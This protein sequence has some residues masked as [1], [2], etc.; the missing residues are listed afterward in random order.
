MKKTSLRLA[1]LILT[2]ALAEIAN[3]TPLNP[4]FESGDT[5]DW[6]VS[7][8]LGTSWLPPFQQPAGEVVIVSNWNPETSEGTAIRPVAGNSFARVGT[9]AAGFFTGGLIYDIYLT[10]SISL[11]QGDILSGWSLFYNGDNASQDSAWVK[12]TDSADN[13]IANPWLAVSGYSS[14]VTP[15]MTPYLSA[16]AWTSW[17]W[18][19]PATGTYQLKLGV[20]TF[21]DNNFASYGLFDDI[22]LSSASGL[23][24][25]TAMPEPSATTLFGLGFAAFAG[26][27]RKSKKQ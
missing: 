8:P 23:Q 14:T 12:V 9:L 17:S 22:T 1:T 11:E 27:W 20:T 21:G 24:T 13:L 18:Q 19:V 16:S 4:S 25:A 5:T 2:L 6:Q 10:Q 3:A 15:D 26:C 7:N